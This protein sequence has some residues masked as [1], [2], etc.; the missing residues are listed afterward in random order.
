[1][2]PL[3]IEFLR[4]QRLHK[5]LDGRQHLKTLFVFT[6][7]FLALSNSLS[8]RVSADDLSRLDHLSGNSLKSELQR[9]LAKDQRALGYKSAKEV[10]FEKIDNHDGEVCCVYSETSCIRTKNVPK[11]TIMNAEHTWPQS[12][13]AVGIAK[14]DLHHLY[15]TKSNVNSIRS[16]FPFC[17]VTRAKWQGGGSYM[18]TD[19]KGQT[20]FEP[21]DEHKGNVARSMFYFSLRYNHKIDKDQEAILRKWNENDPVDKAELLRHK[22]VEDHQNNTNVFVLKPELVSKVS[23]F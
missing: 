9:L 18:G 22:G 1:M 8:A 23:D 13:G 14:S 10:M 2:S 21:P 6:L 7:F 5:L 15:P 12:K 3:H 16:N 19:S 4:L 17:E 20:C 11:H